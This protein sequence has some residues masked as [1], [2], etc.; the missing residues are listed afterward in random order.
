[1]CSYYDATD[2]DAFFNAAQLVSPTARAGHSVAFIGG[3]HRPGPSVIKNTANE[4]CDV[5]V[6]VQ[7]AYVSCARVFM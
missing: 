5:C 2:V 7:P 4:M 1:M 6:G 3:D